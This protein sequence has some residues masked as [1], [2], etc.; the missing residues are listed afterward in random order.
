MR[1]LPRT[2]FALSLLG[3]P[4]CQKRTEAPAPTAVKPAPAVP[5]VRCDVIGA[6]PTGSPSPE[7]T[8]HVRGLRTACVSDSW[9]VPVIACFSKAANDE[10]ERA[11]A[12]QLGE[13]QQDWLRYRLGQAEDRPT[14]WSCDE[15]DGILREAEKCRRVSGTDKD[16]IPEMRIALTDSRMQLK[17]GASVDQLRVAQLRC[18]SLQHL[19]SRHVV[20]MPC[21][22]DTAAP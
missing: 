21:K 19:A 1:S 4:A 20:E 22:T 9:P 2:L 7:L 3:T 13:A 6:K 14:G 16:P 10:A 5:V 15:L 17:P 11:C 12:S 18:L 8:P